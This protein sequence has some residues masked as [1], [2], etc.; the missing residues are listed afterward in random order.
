MYHLIY[1]FASIF[2]P[3][4][5]YLSTTKLQTWLL[6]AVGKQLYKRANW[7]QCKHINCQYFLFF[8]F[9]YS[10]APS[11]IIHR[12]NFKPSSLSPGS[13]HHLCFHFQQ[14][15]S[16]YS[17]YK[18]NCSTTCYFLYASCPKGKCR[19]V[20][21]LGSKTN[22][23]CADVLSPEAL[24]YKSSLLLYQPSNSISSILS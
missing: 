18:L 24:I 9:F 8:F 3:E 23:I 22:P 13:L 10:S 1:P 14:I 12:C 21:L 20:P 19:K 6:S 11:P 4:L 15:I 17:T 16:C 2:N 5:I 7:C